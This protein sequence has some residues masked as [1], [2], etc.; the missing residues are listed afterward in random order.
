MMGGGLTVRCNLLGMGDAC[1]AWHAPACAQGRRPEG[2]RAGGVGEQGWGNWGGCGGR[3]AVQG[4]ARTTGR[5]R[6]WGLRDRSG[7]Q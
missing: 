6:A 5:F 1:A 4:I 2:D 3:F 7:E